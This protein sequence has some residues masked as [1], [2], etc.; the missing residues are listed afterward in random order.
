MLRSMEQDDGPLG[1]LRD[2]SDGG[3][4]QAD[5]EIVK[6]H[7]WMIRESQIKLGSQQGGLNN[8]WRQE[9]LKA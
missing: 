7:S 4:P 3:T 8:S 1:S 5:M 2:G 6:G 9:T